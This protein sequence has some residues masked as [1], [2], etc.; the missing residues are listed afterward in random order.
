MRSDPVTRRRAKELRRELTD[1]EGILWSRI[2]GRQ[3]RGWQFRVQH[4][5]P[6]YVLDF[7][8]IP[9]RLG[10]ELDGATHSTD[11]ERAHDERRRVYLLERG[12]KLVRFWNADVYDNLNGVL[13]SILMRLPPKD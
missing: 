2:K 1:A 5:A 10:I 12:W 3:L 9:L 13:E 6:P 8:C 4:P 11:E 7:A